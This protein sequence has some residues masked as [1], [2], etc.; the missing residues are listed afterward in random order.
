LWFCFALPWWLLNL[1]IISNTLWTFTCL[2][3]KTS[4][5]CYCQFLSG[6]IWF[7]CYWLFWVPYV[8]WLLTS[9][10][11]YTFGEYFLPQYLGYLFTLLIVFFVVQ[12]F[13]VWYNPICLFLLLIFVLLRAYPRNPFPCPE[14]TLLYLLFLVHNFRSHIY[15]FSPFW[16]D[17]CNWNEIG[18]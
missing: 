12:R 14:T 2:F 4:M 5:Y 1:S 9:S 17:F 13:L 3:W 15:A 8:V 11:K 6:I 10:W 7:F 16:V 18:V